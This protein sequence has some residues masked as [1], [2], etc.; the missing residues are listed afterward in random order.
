MSKKIKEC[1][2]CGNLQEKVGIHKIDISLER[3]CPSRGIRFGTISYC[4]VGNKCQNKAREIKGL[5]H[6]EQLK[7]KSLL[8]KK[9]QS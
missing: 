4:L 5:K 8:L 9:N 6:L 2:I 7:S 3:G 1:D